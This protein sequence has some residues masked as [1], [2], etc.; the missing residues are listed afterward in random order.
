M[1]YRPEVIGLVAERESA[2]KVAALKKFIESG[3]AEYRK[4]GLPISSDGRIDMQA[5][6]GVYPDVAKDQANVR[7]WQ[8]DFAK[9]NNPSPQIEGGRPTT[10]GEK[11]EML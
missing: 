1:G 4:E 9:K 7:D 6:R 5:F 2:E 10:D 8:N 3:A 11:L